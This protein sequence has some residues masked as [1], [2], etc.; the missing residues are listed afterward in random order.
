MAPDRAREWIFSIS[1]AHFGQILDPDGSPNRYKIGQ[2]T[3]KAL[4]ETVPEALVV[5][6]CGHRCPETRFSSNLHKFW[7]IFGLFFWSISKTYFE[8]LIQGKSKARN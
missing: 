7:M 4:P 6:F 1:P 5:D 8:F 2:E 3:Q